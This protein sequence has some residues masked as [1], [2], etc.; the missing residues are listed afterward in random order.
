MTKNNRVNIPE[1]FAV[2][3]SRNGLHYA[4]KKHAGAPPIIDCEPLDTLNAG[5]RPIVG[6]W[7]IKTALLPFEGCPLIR[8]KKDPSTK[9][10]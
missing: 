9:V 2:D 4:P 3:A 7:L 8:V 6:A 1:K 10:P 5:R